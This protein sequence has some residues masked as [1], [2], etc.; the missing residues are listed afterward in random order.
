MILKAIQVSLIILS[1]TWWEIA[2][3]T[4]CECSN[5]LAWNLPICSS[6]LLHSLGFAHLRTLTSIVASLRFAHLRTLTSIVAS[7]GFAH[8][9]T[10]TS[11]VASDNGGR[12]YCNSI[13]PPPEMSTNTVQILVL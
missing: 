13:K 10:L 7:L 6:Q 2:A 3:A 12:D 11:I 5:V 1:W 8:L 9:R 4:N